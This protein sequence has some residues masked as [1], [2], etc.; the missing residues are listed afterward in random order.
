MGKEMAWEAIVSF[1]ALGITIISSVVMTMRGLA[2]IEA[3]LRAYFDKRQQETYASLKA[4]INSSRD[5][6]GETIK[7]AREHAELAHKRVDQ[8]IISHQKLELYI[9]DNFIEIGSFNTAV[10]RI[11]K[12]IDSILHKVEKLVER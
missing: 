3:N 2:K 7:A 10:A 4:D 11:E 12:T 8:V 5:M 1:I 6:F 9:R